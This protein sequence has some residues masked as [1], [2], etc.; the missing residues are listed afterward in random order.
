MAKY[1]S[2]SYLLHDGQVVLPGT[3][4]ELTDEQA[5]R[6]GDKLTAVQEVKKKAEERTEEKPE[7]RT[8]EK[9]EEEKP[10]KKKG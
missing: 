6:L 9:P 4:V 1:T 7:E 3:E 8:E 10:K 5:E 2:S